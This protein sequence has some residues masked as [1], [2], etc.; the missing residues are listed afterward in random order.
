MLDFVTNTLLVLTSVT[1]MFGVG[2]YV[3][4]WISD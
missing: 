3:K 4:S 2:I 1:V